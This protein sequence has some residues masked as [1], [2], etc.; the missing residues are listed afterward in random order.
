MY[1]IVILGF[2]IDL[3]ELCVWLKAIR[4]TQKYE[5]EQLDNYNR[6]IDILT[7]CIRVLRSTLD[8]LPLTVLTTWY[9]LELNQLDKV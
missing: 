7:A 2:V 6:G 9:L 8:E 5:I 3:W 1:P 4:Q